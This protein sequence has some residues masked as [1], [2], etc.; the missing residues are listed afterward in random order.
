M[1]LLN[2]CVQGVKLLFPEAAMPVQPLGGRLEQP[3]R[4][5]AIGDTTFF[6]AHDQPGVLEDPQML[7]NR[8]R[9]DVERFPEN[10]HRTLASRE[11][12]DH[13]APRWIGERGKYQ[14]ERLILIHR[15]EMVSYADSV[16]VGHHVSLEAHGRCHHFVVLSAGYT[17][18]FQCRHDVLFERHPVGL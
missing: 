3:P 16:R 7:R 5:P 11:S 14:V 8:G 2:K 18:V 13:R 15:R 10:A 4:K 9:R 6:H 1:L 17:Q 12:F